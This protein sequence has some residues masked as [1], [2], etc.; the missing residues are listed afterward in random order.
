ME[1]S[2]TIKAFIVKQDN[3]ISNSLMSEIQKVDFELNEKLK[4]INEINQKL[5]ERLSDS[6]KTSK[7]NFGSFI[8][9][10]TPA[11]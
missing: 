6:D 3:G 4:K 11:I 5:D 2:D 9:R 10:I 7:V 8:F 1:D